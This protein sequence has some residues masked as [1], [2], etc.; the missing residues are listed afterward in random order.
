MDL[1]TIDKTANL[2]KN[3]SM[4]LM[5]FKLVGQQ[6]AQFGYNPF[7]AMNIFKIKEVLNASEY[8]I[9]K[10]TMNMADFYKGVIE[11]RGDYINVYDTA[12]WF[13][14]EVLHTNDRSVI[15]I[16]EVNN[17]TIGLLVAY[18][19]GVTEK[20]WKELQSSGENTQKIVSQTRVEDELCLIMDIE[21]MIAEITGTDLEKE[22]KVESLGEQYDKIILF[23]DD[24][25]SIRGYVKAVLE[26]LGFQHQIYNDGSGIIEF[27]ETKE[28]RKKVGLIITDLEMPN[29]SGH[30]VIRT[31]KEIMGLDIPVVVHSSMTVGDSV[32]QANQLGADGFIGKI[33]TEELVKTIKKYFRA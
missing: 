23:A 15:V 13:G 12:Q 6:D 18:I 16:C 24:Q 33:D 20:D 9:T 8:R 31:V 22:A 26:N 7:Y 30:T 25:G 17:Q 1:N 21:Q 3:N 11:V 28:N 27:L 5:V 10:T 2:S 19:H 14:H 4:S 32:R 29:V